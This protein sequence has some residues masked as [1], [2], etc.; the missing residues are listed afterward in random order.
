MVELGDT[1]GLGPRAVR[2]G[3]SLPAGVNALV[4]ELEYAHGLGPCPERVGGSNPP[5][6]TIKITRL[7]RVILLS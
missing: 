7:W 6:G 3:G 2:R 1:R 5:E 4:A